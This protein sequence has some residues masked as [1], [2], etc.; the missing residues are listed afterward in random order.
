MKTKTSPPLRSEYNTGLNAVRALQECL[1]N[2][3][4]C[5]G[6]FPHIIGSAF[7]KRT[8]N[9]IRVPAIAVLATLVYPYRRQGIPANAWGWAVCVYLIRACLPHSYRPPVGITWCGHYSVGSIQWVLL[10]EYYSV[11]LTSWVIPS[12]HC[13][14]HSVNTTQWVLPTDHPVPDHTF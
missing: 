14:Y 6:G 12:T 3:L 10:G 11:G 2:S 1:S 8:S 9:C 5:C 4:L 7:T 13:G